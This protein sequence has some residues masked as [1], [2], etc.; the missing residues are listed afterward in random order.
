MQGKSNDCKVNMGLSR[1]GMMGRGGLV[2]VLTFPATAQITVHLAPATTQA[3]EKYVAAA[4]S[5]MDWKARTSAKPGGDVDLTGIGGSPINVEDGMIHDW[6][7]GVLVRGATVEKAL[8]LFQNYAGYKKVFSP[9]VIDSQV[10]QHEGDRW[11][12]RLRISRRSGLISVTFDAEYAIEYRRLGEGRWAIQ[13]HS[14]K[15]AELDGDKPLPVGT[16]QGFLWRINSYWLI[17]PR[18]EG[19]Y[20]ECRAISL[21]RDIP[22]GLGWI[23]RPIVSSLPKD[24][25]RATVEEARNALR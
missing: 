17:E 15:I 20:L 1:L 19:L 9:D 10:L 4:E 2:L 7:G 16:G 3:F 23:V 14:T 12:S 24:S 6:A 21:S 13:S 11:N 8:A 25:L 5:K 18:R 22:T